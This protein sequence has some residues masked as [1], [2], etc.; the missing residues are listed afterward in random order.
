MRLVSKNFGLGSRRDI[1][2]DINVG[3]WEVSY[4]VLMLCQRE[5]TKKQS[6]DCGPQ[7]SPFTF[8]FQIE[9]GDHIAI[10]VTD[11]DFPDY[12]IDMKVRYTYRLAADGKLS[13]LT[14]VATGVKG[15]QQK[16]VSKTHNGSFIQAVVEVLNLAV[17]TE[18]TRMLDTIE[19]QGPK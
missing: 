7:V 4:W 9:P 18:I 10:Q 11:P 8:D 15:I 6:L 2:P 12:K 1:S 17:N 13:Q 16:Y 19:K 5:Y 14:A 3:I